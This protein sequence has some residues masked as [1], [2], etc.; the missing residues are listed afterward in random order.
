MISILPEVTMA[1]IAVLHPPRQLV[2][3]RVGDTHYGLDIESVDEILP[4]LP[5]TETPGAPVGVLGIVDVRKNV[6]PVYDLHV[7]FGVPAP[8]SNPEARLILVD[9]A[10]DP[11]ALLVDAVEE[12][13]NVQRD[14]F[15]GL[16]T[17]GSSSE[18]GYVSGVVRNGDRLILWIDHSRLVPGAVATAAA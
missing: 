4:V 7:K 17:P 15:H 18:V 5:I 1:A 6:V 16:T 9:V 10:G 8:N 13:L 12:V 3:F 2:L 14:D 11:V